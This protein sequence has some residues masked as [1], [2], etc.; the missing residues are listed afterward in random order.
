MKKIIAIISVI[1]VAGFTHAYAA[2]KI[3]SVNQLATASFNRDFVSA[4]N[5]SWQQEKEFTKATFTLNNQIMYAYYGNE[6]GELL[7]VARNILSDQL[8]IGLM[9]SLKR[10]YANHWVSNLFEM[11]SNGQT[12]YYAT[13]ENVDE[14]LILKSDGNEWSVFK[15]EKK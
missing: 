5:V 1:M 10:D 8:P 11:A 4:K 14:T 6:N 3:K 2:D 15:R 12:N 9:T 7:A 13:V